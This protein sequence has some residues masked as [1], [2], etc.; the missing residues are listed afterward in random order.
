LPCRGQ[1]LFYRC[2]SKG[3]TGKPVPQKGTPSIV[4]R[5]TERVLLDE[6]DLRASGQHPTEVVL[7]ET[8]QGRGILDVVNGASPKSVEDD[9]EIR[10]RKKFLRKIGYKL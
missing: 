7:A 2:N 3:C 9:G 6:P 10:W 4:L 5:A 8:E 1:G